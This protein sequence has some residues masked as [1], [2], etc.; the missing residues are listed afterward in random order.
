VEALRRLEE[1]PSVPNSDATHPSFGRRIEELEVF[2]NELERS[3]E[4]YKRGVEA[5]ES[6]DFE[7]AMEGFEIFAKQFPQASEGWI[8]LGSAQLAAIPR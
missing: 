8:N 6:G 4:L 3:I 5:F 7:T 1:E 2:R